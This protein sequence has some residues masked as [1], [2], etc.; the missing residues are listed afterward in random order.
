MGNEPQNLFKILQ[1]VALCDFGVLTIT[2]FD[3]GLKK[4]NTLMQFTNR[5]HVSEQ[6]Q[7]KFLKTIFN[8]I[9]IL[10]KSSTSK[11]LY[12]N[13]ETYAKST[14]LKFSKNDIYFFLSFIIILLNFFLMVSLFLSCFSPL[15]E[16]LT[17]IISPM[18]F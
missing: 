16:K 5:Y 3:M 2:A 18:I 11:L 12:T 15:F 6:M 10:Y 17:F 13:I 14:N 9:L 8:N 7:A 1:A 4:K